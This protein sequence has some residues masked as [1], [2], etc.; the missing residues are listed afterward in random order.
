MGSLHFQ[1]DCSTLNFMIK[2]SKK[3]A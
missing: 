2:Q 1:K 3:T